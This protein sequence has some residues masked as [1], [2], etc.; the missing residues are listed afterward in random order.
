[1][2]SRERV[3]PVGLPGLMTTSPRTATPAS[4]ALAS[5]AFR[6]AESLKAPH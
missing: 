4:R 6:S 3:L 5:E 2:F 1:M